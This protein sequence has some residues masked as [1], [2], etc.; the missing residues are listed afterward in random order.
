MAGCCQAEVLVVGLAGV[1]IN[2]IFMGSGK[3]GTVRGVVSDTTEGVAGGI[4]AE[5]PRLPPDLF[6]GPMVLDLEGHL[7]AFLE[8][9][10][11]R[12]GVLRDAV[13]GVRASL[14]T[15]M[16]TIAGN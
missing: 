13:R 12:N 11:S 16:N 15:A 1:A 10:A 2:Q 8:G 4:V 6:T 5:V 14:K 7:R 9:R 3:D